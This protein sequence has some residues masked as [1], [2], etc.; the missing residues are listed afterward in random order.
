MTGL[1]WTVI[2]LYFLVIGFI[3]WGYGRGQRDSIDYFLAGRNAGFVAVGESIYT[4]NIGSDGYLR[5]ARERV[6][7]RCIR[8]CH[9]DRDLHCFWRNA[10]NHGHCCPA[11]GHRALRIIRHHYPRVAHVM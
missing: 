9:S 3:A 1:D 10:S 6:W 2:N 11:G 7:G 5:F 4:S 8:H